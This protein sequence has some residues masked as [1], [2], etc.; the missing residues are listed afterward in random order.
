MTIHIPG[1]FRILLAPVVALTLGLTTTRAAAAE[2]A[3]PAAAGAKTLSVKTPIHINN[4][5]AALGCLPGD[6]EDEM[7]TMGISSSDGKLD[8]AAVAKLCAKHGFVYVPPAAPPVVIRDK[9][10]DDTGKVF[11]SEDA[12]IAASRGALK[13]DPLLTDAEYQ[14]A[15]IYTQRQQYKK[16]AKL[17]HKLARNTNTYTKKARLMQSEADCIF[18]IGRYA[19]ADDIYRDLLKNYGSFID[20]HHVVG[21]LRNLAQKY[22]DGKVSWL[23]ISKIYQ[24]IEIYKLITE[25]APAEDLVVVDNLNLINIYM[26][27][28]D[29]DLAIAQQQHVLK[30]YPQTE[31]AAY[32]AFLMAKAYYLM[33]LKFDQDADN[34]LQ[35]SILF[36]DF[37]ATHPEHSLVKDANLLLAK[38]QER[39]GRKLVDRANFYWTSHYWFRPDDARRYLYD[40]IHDYPETEAG[41]EAQKLID[42]IKAT[43]GVTME[44]GRKPKP[45]AEKKPGLPDKVFGKP[46]VPNPEKL[47]ATPLT[48]NQYSDDPQKK[49][50]LPLEKTPGTGIEKVQPPPIPMTP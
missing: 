42:V 47:P 11:S 3:P 34:A 31:Q 2:L 43:G 13:P 45:A 27:E 7:A 6:L 38:C 4:L 49:W 14:E 33:S 48:R 35:A 19:D 20:Y 1:I 24:T 41:A 23:G 21:Q 26:D 15:N 39:L 30:R 16:A 10:Q 44:P 25:L 12:A 9:Y 46:Y 37:I 22:K 36:K 40:A 5:A 8:A 32:A 18:E 28:E 29:Y 17:Y 50:L